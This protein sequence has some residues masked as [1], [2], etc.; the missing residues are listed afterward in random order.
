M[1]ARL[2]PCAISRRAEARPT[3]RSTA[4]TANGRRS[5][6]AI[7]GFIG[8]AVRHVA[9][10][11]V[12]HRR[13]DVRA[14]IV[15]ENVGAERAEDLALVEAAQEEHLVD[16]D[17]PCAQRA[18]DAL[19]RGRAARRDERGD[20][21]ARFFAEIGLDPVQAARNSL[22]GPPDSG[23]SAAS[24]SLLENASRPPSR[25]TRSASSE[26][27]TA[28]PSKAMRSPSVS[29]C[30]PRRQDRRRG[31][32]FLQHPPHVVRI[33]RKEQVR[34]EGGRHSATWPRPW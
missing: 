26:K 11:D 7:L 32:T 25:Y 18:N 17:V 15:E 24:A 12:F 9:R 13:L 33:G 31:M 2:Q 4:F 5:T 14:L 8:D 28:S 19:V 34:A 20:D 22:K 10:G 1:W 29:V 23:S 3:T 30:S 16:A 21:R 6:R 27:S